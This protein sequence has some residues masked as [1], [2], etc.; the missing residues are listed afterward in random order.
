MPFV[1]ALV[2]SGLVNKDAFSHLGKTHLGHAFSHLQKGEASRGRGEPRGRR[3]EGEAS[4]GGGEPRGRRAERETNA[5]RA[6]GEAIV[7]KC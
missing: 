3:A 1:Y 7:S 5:T 4:R 2:H 6:E